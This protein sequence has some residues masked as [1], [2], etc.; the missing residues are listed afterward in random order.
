MEFCFPRWSV[1]DRCCP[2]VHAPA[3]PHKA[4]ESGLQPLHPLK[5]SRAASCGSGSSEPSSGSCFVANCQQPARQPRPAAGDR[6]GRPAV[7]AMAGQR[8][9][10]AEVADRLAASRSPI[11]HKPRRGAVRIPPKPQ[12][13]IAL[14]VPTEQTI[15]A[16]ARPAYRCGRGAFSANQVPPESEP[17]LDPGLHHATALE[18]RRRAQPCRCP[19]APC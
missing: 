2:V 10:V 1:G 5:R 16:S 7:L 17:G 18:T 11:A 14:S 6:A 3:V 19:S 13:H 9:Q 4:P 15:Q 12:M 8:S